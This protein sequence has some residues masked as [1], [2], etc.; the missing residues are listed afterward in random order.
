AAASLAKAY[1]ENGS[2]RLRCLEDFSN[3]LSPE[4]RQSLY[5]DLAKSDLCLD[6]AA[7]H[8]ELF[9]AALRAEKLN[10][11]EEHLREILSYDPFAAG[12]TLQLAQA[13]N[14]SRQSER[15]L[16]LLEGS[17]AVVPQ[18]PALVKEKGSAFQ[19]LGRSE[20][21]VAAW[22]ASLAIKS[23][24]PDLQEYL[25]LHAPGGEDYYSAFRVAYQD[26]V[27]QAQQESD[28]TL[29]KEANYETLLEQK[30]VQVESNGSS[31]ATYH[32]VYRFVSEDGLQSLRSVPIWYVPEREKVTIKVARLHQADGSELTL[33]QVRD[34]SS[35]RLSGVSTKLYYDYISKQI[36]VTGAVEGS[37]LELEYE[38]AEKSAPLYADYF[39]DV[40]YFGSDEPTFRSEYVLIT[41]MDKPFYYEIFR[42]DAKPTIAEMPSKGQR[43][44]RWTLTN[45]P[46]RKREPGRPPSSE[47]LPYLKVTTF[48]TWDD[49]SR[50]YWG[51]IKDQFH[52]TDDIKARVAGI[53]GDAKTPEQKARALY[54]FVVSDIRYL[55]YELGVHGYKPHAAVEVCN[56]QY[57]DCKDKATLLVAMLQE[58]GISANLV[59]IRTRQR[60]EIDYS[61]PS[62]GLFNHAI[63]VIPDLNGERYFL[64]ATATYSGFDELPYGDRGRHVFV[65]GKE[66]GYFA[67]IPEAISS[68]N[69]TTYTMNLKIQSDLS[70]EGR[71]ENFYRGEIA[72]SIRVYYGTREKAVQNVLSALNSTFAGSTVSDLEIPD[73]QNLDVSP[74][75]KYSLRIPSFAK[76]SGDVARFK[77]VLFPREY[78]RNQAILAEREYDLITDYPQIA[79]QRYRFEI[80]EGWTAAVLPE[81]Y[82]ERGPFG[83]VSYQCR[84]EGKTIVLEY[85]QEFTTTRVRAADYP[86]YRRFLNAVDRCEAQEVVLRPSS[87]T[88]GA[89][90]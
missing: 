39:G 24:Q 30:V 28:P 88:S 21:A 89:G 5:E 8:R 55:G 13:L 53:V 71:R 85:R 60:G 76:R 40:V 31:R 83:A 18:N 29:L 4:T 49:V 65:V 81:P 43:V 20:E 22:Q 25:S 50:W 47:I 46:G 32:Y 27:A 63:A 35:S 41:P 52:L 7:L 2:V 33:D 42:N 45:L 23:N 62:L 75:M 86:E 66:G 64:D 59:L 1:P 90:Q 69:Q 44:Y 73:L 17:L 11:A 37:V 36:S 3:H 82:M 58:A 79:L 19:L 6:R 12:E 87:R 80:P 51:L 56:A 15:A 10:E 14:A 16:K 26:I 57:G 68:D 38:V 9:A 34:D 78:S 48:Q 61:V 77:P 70:A 74:W 67:D 54:N 84:L 72:P